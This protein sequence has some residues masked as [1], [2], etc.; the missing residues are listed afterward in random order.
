MDRLTAAV[1]QHRRPVGGRVGA[2]VARRLTID[3]LDVL[4]VGGDVDRSEELVEVTGAGMAGV[5]DR[6]VGAEL[7]QVALD[8]ELTDATLRAGE[9]VIGRDIDDARRAGTRR[10]RPTAGRE[11]GNGDEHE[12]SQRASVSPAR[13]E[14]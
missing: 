11:T 13:R 1:E 2:L 3:Q 12:H 10:V 5:D 7:V 9:D 4:R 14:P 8:D 6:V